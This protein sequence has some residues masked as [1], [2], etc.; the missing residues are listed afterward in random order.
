MNP[1]DVIVVGAGHAGCEAALASARMGC[2][3]LLLTVDMDK[4]A[5]MSCNPAIGGIAK[6]HL[7][8]EIDALGGEMGRNADRAGIQFRKLNTRKGAAVQA[9]RA[10][11]D[12]WIYRYE[13]KKVLERE[14]NLSLKQAKV[15][16][17]IQ[18][19]M[20]VCG[21]VTQFRDRIP[22]R[23]VIITTGTFLTGLMHFGDVKIRGGRAGEPSAD[24]LPRAL[25]HL[26]LKLR[27]LK[28]G[29]TPRLDGRT[30]V[31]SSLARQEGDPTC[32][33]FSILT[34]AL[35]LP[36]VA[37][38]ITYTNEHTHEVI[39]KYLPLSPL[40]SGE[41]VGRGPRYCPSIE[42]KVLKFPDKSRHL[43]FLEPEGLQTY[44]VYP[45]G[46]STSLPPWVQLEYLRTIPGLEGVEIV[47]PGYAVEYDAVD[48]RALEPTLAVRGLE[49]LYLAGQINGTT[50]YEEAAAQGLV[51][52]IN[53]ALYVR[54]DPPFV[55]GRE[56]GYIGVMINDLVTRGVDEPYRM[57]TSRA[58]YRLLLREDNAA[59]RLTPRGRALGLVKDEQWR[60]FVSSQEAK[61]RLKETWESMRIPGEK[62]AGIVPELRGELAGTTLTIAELIQRPEVTLEDLARVGAI[63]EGVPH[64][65]VSTLYVDLRYSGYISRELREIERMKKLRD[66]P[67]PPDLPY[68]R[69]K[70]LRH[71]WV[72]KLTRLKPATLGEIRNL[73]GMTPVTLQLIEGY[74]RLYYAECGVEQGGDSLPYAPGDEIGTGA[75]SI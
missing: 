66:L 6:G 15:V 51:A 1:Y 29:T 2:R 45:N 16:D 43:V 73:P 49:G 12:R 71:E 40:Y 69:I 14:P 39:R 38:H 65:V 50:G 41:I 62:L 10:Q 23:A 31:Y 18:E 70:G 13:M 7:V 20:R 60:R 19:G 46:L 63:P 34:D 44:E 3:V 58:E 54:G 30:I 33:P 75:S 36:Q 67:V 64:E 35:P 59:E 57:F 53:A 28:T 4:I 26:G 37:C 61:E 55:I 72:E 27:R 17:L 24:E 32:P 52:G 74:L 22:A 8:K 47:R 42:D 21:V 25:E 5:H 68:S 48:P 11:E 56:E 9:T